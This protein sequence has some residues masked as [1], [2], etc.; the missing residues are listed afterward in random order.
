[1]LQW[2]S[3]GYTFYDF[4]NVDN[5]VSLMDESKDKPDEAQNVQQQTPRNLEP[6]DNIFRR[7]SIPYMLTGIFDNSAIID[8]QIV[9][10]GARIQKATVESINIDS[11]VLEMEGG[12]TRTISIF[13]PANMQPIPEQQISAGLGQEQSGGG[14]PQGNNNKKRRKANKQQ[15][16]DMVMPAPPQAPSNQGLPPGFDKVPPEFREKAM[17]KWNSLSEEE[18]NQVLQHNQ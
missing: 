3:F 12:A 14:Q 18:K 16:R 6:K 10:A 13:S 4:R 15:S 1:M 9:S 8:G 5:K 11:V 17:E 2:L 7:T